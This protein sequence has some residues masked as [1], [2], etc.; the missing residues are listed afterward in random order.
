[1]ISQNFLKISIKKTLSNV[2]NLSSVNFAAYHE[3]VIDHY[4]K[5]EMSAL[6]TKMIKMSEQDWSELLPAET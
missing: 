1:M 3:K 2:S 6:L 4:E 5:P